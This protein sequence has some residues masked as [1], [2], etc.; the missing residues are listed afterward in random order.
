MKYP[1]AVAS[2]E[3]GIRVTNGTSR[4]WV[5]W[6]IHGGQIGLPGHEIPTEAVRGG[7]VWSMRAP[8]EVVGAEI[9]EGKNVRGER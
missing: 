2:F 8:G 6:T 9:L 1:P 4:F 3:S 5:A 7:W